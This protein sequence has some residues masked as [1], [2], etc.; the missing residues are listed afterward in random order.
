MYKIFV[1]SKS[2][3]MPIKMD[4]N[5][6]AGYYWKTKKICKER[7]WKLSKSSPQK[8][9]TKVNVVGNDIKKFTDMKNKGWLNIDKSIMNS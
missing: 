5:S 3:L 8:K 1:L 2:L 9:K 6:S 4:N 7:P